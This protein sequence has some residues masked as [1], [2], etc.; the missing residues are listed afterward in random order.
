[1]GIANTEMAA[2]WDEEATGWIEY[3]D[4]YERS[5]LGLWRLF[6][7]GVTLN[8]SYRVLDLGCGTGGRTR[9]L[10]ELVPQGS[11]VGVDLSTRMVAHAREVTAREGV[12]NIEFIDGDAQVFP[13]EPDHFDLAV[14]SF[15]SM[16]FADPIAA[17]TNI[18][19]ALRPGGRLALLTWRPVADNKWLVAFRTA[20]AWARSPGTTDECARPVR[21]RRPGSRPACARGR[22]FQR[23]RARSA[24]RGP[25]F[26]S[27]PRLGVSLRQLDGRHEGPDVRTRRRRSPARSRVGTGDPRGPRDSGRRTHRCRRL[28]R[29]RRTSLTSPGLATSADDSDLAL[30]TLSASS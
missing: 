17:F 4:S 8:E 25:R 2:A 3:E 30:I 7:T 24:R 1:M 16:F 18:R 29:D 21:A 19:R 22:R 11:V 14:S 5:G 23:H 27:G 6:L 10:A 15:G 12:T 9:S 28:A 20:L 26:R 13:F